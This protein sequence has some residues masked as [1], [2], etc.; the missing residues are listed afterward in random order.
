MRFK[1]ERL[2]MGELIK[3]GWES[4]PIRDSY[5]WDNKTDDY[6]RNGNG[7]IWTCSFKWA[8]WCSKKWNKEFSKEGV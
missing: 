3:F 6:V 5:V 8:V 2:T 7:R 4:H 1:A